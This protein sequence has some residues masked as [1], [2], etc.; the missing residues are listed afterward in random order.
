M[1]GKKLRELRRKS[2]KTMRQISYESGVTEGA[3]T[4]IETGKTPNPGIGTLTALA[5]A[6]GCKITDFID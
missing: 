3:I 2:G 4:L 6:I 1:N 5:R